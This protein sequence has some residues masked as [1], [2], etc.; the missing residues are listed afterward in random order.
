MAED[1]AAPRRVRIFLIDDH[2]VVR[3]GFARAFA[4]EGDFEITGEAATAAEALAEAPAANPD[5]VVVDLHLPDRDG[6]DLIAA[7]R[8]VLP[9]ARLVV[10][11]GYDDEYR[12]TEALRAGAHG[13]LLK[14]ASIERIIAGIREAAAGGTPLSPQLTDGVLRAMRK[15]GRG[16]GAGAIDVL[17]AREIQVLRLF[18]SGRS[19]REVA[20]SL[21][22]SPK[23]VETHR[24]RIY[25]KLG[26]KGVVDL[27]RIAVRS[28]L[29]EA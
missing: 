8:T 13:Y 3:E 21:G 28:G 10:V 23:T 26:C 17:T 7:L 29:V 5:V 24:I 12:V 20:Q 19:T 6:P 2:P 16:G 1:L 27:T 18:A 25:D 14:A 9:N 15:T 22:I 11:S 4:A